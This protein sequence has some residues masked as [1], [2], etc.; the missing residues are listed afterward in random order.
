MEQLEP[1]EVY[2]QSES[3]TG[4]VFNNVDKVSPEAA[5]GAAGVD[6]VIVEVVE[7]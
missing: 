1:R 6:I 7:L 4:V 3:Q 5:G 2:L